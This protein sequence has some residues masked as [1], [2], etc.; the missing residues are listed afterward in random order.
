MWK[1]FLK[2]KITDMSSQF[3][4]ANS[5]EYN[6]ASSQFHDANQQNIEKKSIRVYHDLEWYIKPHIPHTVHPYVFA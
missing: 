2:D 3:H 6:N 4:D 1:Q 5:P